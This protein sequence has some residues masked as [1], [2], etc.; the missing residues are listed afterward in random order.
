MPAPPNYRIIYNWDGAPHGYSP[1]PQSMDDF[2]EK[3]YA[4]LLSTQVGAL[5]WST[6]GQGSRFPSDVLEFIGEERGRHYDSASGFTAGENIRQMYDRGEDPQ[7][8]LIERG[9]QLSKHVYASIRMN[10]NHFG[11]AQIA[12]LGA[13]HRAG[14]VETLR[15][16]HPQWLLG[17]QTSEWFA[18]SW[19]MAVPEVRQLR[20]RH[21]EEVCRRYDWDGVELDWQRHAFHFPQDDAYRLRYLLTDLQRAIRQMTRKLAEERG[22]PFYLAARVAGSLEMCR[23][24]GYD[25]PTWIKEGLVDVLIPAGNAVTDADIHVAEFSRACEGTEVAVYPGFDS[26]LPDPFVGPED[27]CEKDRLRTRAIASRYHQAGASGIYI[28]NWHADAHSKRS[29]LSTIGSP[30]TLSGTDK[31]YAATHRYVQ[32]KGAWRGA[33]RI[34]RIYGQV[35]VELTRTLTAD[36]PVIVLQIAENFDAHRPAALQLRL[37]LNQFA[38]GDLVDISLDGQLLRSPTADPCRLENP[39]PPGGA[40]Q[41]SPQW[42]QISEVSSA[43]WLCYDLTSTSIAG[44]EHAV[45]V[46]LQ[47]RHPQITAPLILTD[48]EFVVR[49]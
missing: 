12:D 48:V 44:G 16:D 1:V 49:Y 41:P 25:I 21:V 28:F 31:I 47:K 42:R 2:L 14:R 43:V 10:D 37:R 11:G 33:F 26:N 5:F 3:V 23:R 40:F 39:S 32:Q 13:L 30:E 45:R 34:D 20:F 18:L 4:P 6:G 22:R 36:G 46:V 17:D 9:R 27:V 29:L 15:H 38:D 19:N 24:I 7:R 8:S 35:P